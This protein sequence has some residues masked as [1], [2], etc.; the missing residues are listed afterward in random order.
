MET[1]RDYTNQLIDELFEL[2]G[3]FFA[4]GDKQIKEQAD[5]AI[6]YVSLGSGIICPKDNAQALAKGM[7]NINKLTVIR[8]LWLNSPEFIIEREFYNYETQIAM[9]TADLIESLSDYKKYYP[10]LFTDEIINKTVKECF[11]KAAEKDWF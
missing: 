8:D 7:K 1:T 6:K 9:D 3:A 5:P 10:E 4:I 11:N 2:H